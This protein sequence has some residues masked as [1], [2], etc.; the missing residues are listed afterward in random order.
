MQNCKL[1]YYAKLYNFGIKFKTR[2]LRDNHSV[3]KQLTLKPKPS[4]ITASLSQT[5]ATVDSNL[6][7]LLSR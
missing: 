4:L 1:N 5:N 6:N 3:I 2:C 7:R